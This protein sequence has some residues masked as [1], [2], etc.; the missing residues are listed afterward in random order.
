MPDETNTINN[1]ASCYKVAVQFS[2][3]YLYLPALT[4]FVEWQWVSY[5]YRPN[6]TILHHFGDTAA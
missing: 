6:N 5:F 4:K 2:A 1:A 3:S